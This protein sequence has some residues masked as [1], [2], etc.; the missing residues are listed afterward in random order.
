MPW[1]HLFRGTN[2]YF[3]TAVL[4]LVWLL[5]G[6]LVTI[7]NILNISL[8]YLLWRTVHSLKCHTPLLKKPI[9]FTEIPWKSFCFHKNL[10]TFLRSELPMLAYRKT[11]TW[12]L[13]TLRWEPEIGDTNVGPLDGG[14]LDGTLG[15]GNP[16]VGPLNWQFVF[17][18]I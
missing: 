11:G 12:D 5:R 1:L 9:V 7:F 14:T 10:Y 16:W 4:F 13:E 6:Q 17:P 2:F 15:W 8:M 3:R 18:W